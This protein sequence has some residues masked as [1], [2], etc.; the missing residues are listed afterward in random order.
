MRL[1]FKMHGLAASLVDGS[2]HTTQSYACLGKDPAGG[3]PHDRSGD[4]KALQAA[5]GGWTTGS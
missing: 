4:D 3:K 5:R 1:H 2:G